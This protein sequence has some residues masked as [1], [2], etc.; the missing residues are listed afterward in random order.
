MKAR[1]G[2]TRRSFLTRIAAGTTIGG[3]VL[4]IVGGEAE[5]FQ[6]SDK[7]R[8]PLHDRVG[9]GHTRP[10]TMSAGDHDSGPNGD[11]MGNRRLAIEFSGA[12]DADSGPGADPQGFSRSWRG[13]VATEERERPMERETRNRVRRRAPSRPSR[14]PP[15]D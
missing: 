12:T 14:R 2:L 8:G 13:P 3:S 9:H 7:D 6:Y 11:P 5:A 4:V 1:Q 10:G 15:P